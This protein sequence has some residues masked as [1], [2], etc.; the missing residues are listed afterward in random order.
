MQIE[1][2][3]IEQMSASVFREKILKLLKKYMKERKVKFKL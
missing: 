2:A 3:D 1:N